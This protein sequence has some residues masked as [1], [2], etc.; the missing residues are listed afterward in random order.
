MPRISNLPDG[1]VSAILGLITNRV[2]PSNLVLRLFTND[3][4][5]SDIDKTLDY[6]EATGGGYAPILVPPSD[7]A[8]SK[9]SVTTTKTFLFTGS[10]APVF[11]WML[12]QQATGTL[13]EVARFLEAP[14]TIPGPGYRIKIDIGIE[15]IREQKQQD[16]MNII[17]LFDTQP[18]TKTWT[19]ETSGNYRV[20]VVGSGGGGAS[21]SATRGGD[22]GG[23]AE[24][25]IAIAE[26]QSFVYAISAGGNPGNAGGATNWADILTA[27]G[28]AHGDAVAAR[29]AGSGG[30][31][32][33]TGGLGGTNGGGGAS[34][35]RIGNGGDGDIGGGGWGQDSCSTQGGSGQGDGFGLGWCPGQGGTVNGYGQAGIT[36][37]PGGYGSGGAGGDYQT[38]PSSGGIGGGGGATARH[39]IMCGS[40]GIGG[41]GATHIT[42]KA[43]SSKGGNGAV[44]IEKF[45]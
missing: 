30:S 9:A 37:T 42:S 32:N 6:Q 18:G 41:G 24:R 2:Q 23:Y 14:I 8:F 43:Y 16:T 7:W 38:L 33:T 22:G 29:G 36:T 3:R 44:I 19:C 12:T 17:M 13:M 35:S 27:T 10:H 25:I 5:P 31:T 1:A 45:S 40:A 34:G 39:G 20:A 21:T 11:G 28:G 15:I 26:G 4:T